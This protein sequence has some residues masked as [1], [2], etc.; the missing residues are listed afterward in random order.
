MGDENIILF[1]FTSHSFYGNFFVVV[2]KFNEMYSEIWGREKGGLSVG[3]LPLIHRLSGLSRTKTLQCGR[4]GSSQ[5]GKV[6][7]DGWLL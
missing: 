4:N 2:C 5:E 6:I 3:D 7:S 1:V